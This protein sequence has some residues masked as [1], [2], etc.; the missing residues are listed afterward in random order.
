MFFWKERMPNPE[1][2]LRANYFSLINKLIN[3]LNK[4]CESVPGWLYLGSKLWVESLLL[5]LLI[6]S[7]SALPVEALLLLLLAAP[8]VQG[9]GVGGAGSGRRLWLGAP[10][11]LLCPPILTAAQQGQELDRFRLKL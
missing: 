11:Q 1:I 7:L 10:Q 3:L 6:L 2:Y 4:M 9:I 8:S 5:P